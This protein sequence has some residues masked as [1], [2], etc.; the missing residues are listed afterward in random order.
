M[1]L[2]DYSKLEAAADAFLEGTN[3]C[4]YDVRDRGITYRDSRYCA[5]LEKLSES[6]LAAGGDNPDGGEPSIIY[7]KGQRALKFVWM[8]RAI[9]ELGGGHQNAWIW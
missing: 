9:S 6:Y 7:A 3:E 2:K 5:L 4:I 8:A 1:H